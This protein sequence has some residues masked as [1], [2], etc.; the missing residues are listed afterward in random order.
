MK[1]PQLAELESAADIVDSDDVDAK[2]QKVLQ[3]SDFK[4]SHIDDNAPPPR[5]QGKAKK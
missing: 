2:A 3:L 5:S 4:C 1:R